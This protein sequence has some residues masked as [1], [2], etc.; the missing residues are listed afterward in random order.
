MK[1]RFLILGKLIVLAAVIILAAWSVIALISNSSSRTLA[2][3]FTLAIDLPMIWYGIAVFLIFAVSIAGTLINRSRKE[4]ENFFGF[5]YFFVFS[6]A[7]VSAY[8]L[9]FYRDIVR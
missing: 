7:L 4:D 9:L 2:E 1:K 5:L 3:Q 8:L 6:V